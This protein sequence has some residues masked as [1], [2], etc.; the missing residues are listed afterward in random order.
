MSYDIILIFYI[1]A[2]IP[3][4]QCPIYKSWNYCSCFISYCHHNNWES[5]EWTNISLCKSFV[6]KLIVCYI[7][8]VHASVSNKTRSNSPGQKWLQIEKKGNHFIIGLFEFWCNDDLGWH[9]ECR[10][11]TVYCLVFG[12]YLISIDLCERAELQNRMLFCV[13][14]LLIRAEYLLISAHQK[15]VKNW[16][17]ESLS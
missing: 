17:L 6:I 4:S 9:W 16:G 13:Y 10:T 15:F 8:D 5:N 1:Q 3:N 14:C 7:R 12:L 11:G 2:T